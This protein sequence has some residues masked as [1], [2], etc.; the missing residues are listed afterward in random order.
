MV[1]DVAM[2]PQPSETG[3]VRIP[4]HVATLAM[5]GMMIVDNAHLETLAETC[6]RLNRWEFQLVIA[7]LRVP[8]GNSSPVNPIALF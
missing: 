8:T 2:D 6:A 7:P 1:S 5:M 4:W 3:N